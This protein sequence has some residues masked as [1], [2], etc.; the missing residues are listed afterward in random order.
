M[1]KSCF[2]NYVFLVI[3]HVAAIFSHFYVRFL[4]LYILAII[5]IFSHLKI[6]PP[7]VRSTFH[8]L[9]FNELVNL[10]ISH[11]CYA[12]HQQLQSKTFHIEYRIKIYT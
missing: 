3:N 4:K 5:Y 10:P 1:A 11:L 12:D 2:T 6:P 8:M 9:Q 7:I